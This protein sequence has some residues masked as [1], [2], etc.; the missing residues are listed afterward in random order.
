MRT[1]SQHP[2]LYVVCLF[3]RQHIF[4]FLCVYVI[5]SVV[6]CCRPL[7]SLSQCHQLLRQPGGSMK[8]R[9]RWQRERERWSMAQSR[10]TAAVEQH[11][12]T[13]HVLLV[14]ERLYQCVW[15]CLSAHILNHIEK[16]HF[17]FY[18]LLL[19]EKRTLQYYTSVHK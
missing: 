9:E 11:W 15:S 12:D 13:V 7:S 10:L 2:R 18:N 6:V 4:A 17:L 19:T 5:A 14:C 3:V 8:A 16:Q 1:G